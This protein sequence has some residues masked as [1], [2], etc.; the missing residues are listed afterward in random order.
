[1]KS[2][3]PLNGNIKRRTPFRKCVCETR[4][5]KELELENATLSA[6]IWSLFPLRLDSTVILHCTNRT[7][8]RK[9]GQ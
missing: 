5:N 2:V 1:M 8:K 3:M 6:L 4:G 9:I 7:Q